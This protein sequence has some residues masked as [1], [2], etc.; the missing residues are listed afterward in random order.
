MGN[1]TPKYLLERDRKIMAAKMMAVSAKIPDIASPATGVTA[2][3][4]E[5]P[6]V[7]PPSVT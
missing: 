7:S 3:S 4:Q 6:T 5:I 1:P 2:S